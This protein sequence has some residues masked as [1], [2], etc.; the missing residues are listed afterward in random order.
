MFKKRYV[1]IMIYLLNKTSCC[2]Q[3]GVCCTIYVYKY[4]KQSLYGY[5][6]Y[7]EQNPTTPYNSR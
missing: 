7:L 2:T 5:P 6:T 3:N 1:Y 4:R